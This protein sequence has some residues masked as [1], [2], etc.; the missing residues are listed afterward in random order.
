MVT[1][2]YCPVDGIDVDKI[3]EDIDTKSP[4]KIIIFNELEWDLPQFNKKITSKIKSNNIDLK[5]VFGG[6]PD[7]FYTNYA[8][9]I[10][11]SFDNLIFW[12]TYWINWSEMC[13]KW[14]I[15]YKNHVVN[16][17]F[18][19]KLIS[20]NNKCHRHRQALVDH[21]AK[22]DLI[23]D[24]VVSWHKFNESEFHAYDFKYFHNNV[25]TINDDFI[26]RPDSFYIPEQWH[27]SFLHVV[28]EATDRAYIISEKTVNPILLKKPFVC[29]SKKGYNRKLTDLGF[30]LYDEI[31]D[32]SYDDLDDLTDRADRL[33]YSIKQMGN[34]YKDLYNLL[35]PKIKHNYN[36]CLEIIHDIR[37][38]PNIIKENVETRDSNFMSI[39]TAP[40]YIDICKNYC[41]D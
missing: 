1:L 5:I 8:N 3:E 18:K 35:K 14:A 28:G 30:V 26:N 7:E 29:I 38:V 23:K 24:N 31:L 39:H 17:D 41:N 6:F 27:E 25:M 11:L 34:N 20:L 32:Y 22:Y 12:P 33:C 15:D 16:T 4:D 19:Y 40:R 37:Y 10:G 13:L 9:R 2:C 36:R 21:L